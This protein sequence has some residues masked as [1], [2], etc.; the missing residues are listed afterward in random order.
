MAFRR[1][2]D[3]RTTLVRLAVAAGS[4]FALRHTGPVFNDIGAFNLV[5]AG[6]SVALAVSGTLLVSEG[7]FRL[8][9]YFKWLAVNTPEGN[10]GDGGFVRSI[11]ELRADLIPFPMPGPYWGKLGRRA[12]FADFTMA[13]I[14]GPTGS[15][16]DVGHNGPNILSIK[17]SKLV[18]D[19][20]GDTSP[21][22]VPA[23]RARGEE[24]RILNFGAMFTDIL[25]E[26]DQYN[27]LH[28][29]ADSFFRPGGI[30]DVASDLTEFALIIYPASKDGKSGTENSNFWEGGSRSKIRLAICVVILIMGYDA[31]LGD[32]LGLLQDR[33]ALLWH[34][35]WIAGRLEDDNG[36]PLVF[37]MHE[38]PWVD[39]QD[40][41]D[42]DRFATYLRGLAAS[43]AD[44]LNADDSRTADSFLQGSL[45]AMEPHN[46]TT[47]AHKIVQSSTFRFADMKEPGRTVTVFMVADDTRLEANRPIIELIQHCAITEW[48]RAPHK[49]VPVYFL[50]NEAANF[51]I[52]NLREIL[53]FA[54]AY[55][56][57]VALYLQGLSAFRASYSKETLDTVFSEQDALLVLPGQS[58]PD[59]LKLLETYLSQESYVE[60]EYGGDNRGPFG[61]KG[62]GIK[63][64]GRAVMSAESIRRSK[65][66]ILWLKKN[67]PAKVELPSIAGIVPFRTQQA[68]NPFFGKPYR[69]PV[70]LRLWRYMWPG[71][72]VQ[73]ALS[74]FRTL[75]F[76]RRS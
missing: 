19:L 1:Q 5:T 35:L 66:A 23:L 36:N 13:C 20:K 55:G 29:I 22:Y 24:V 68:I 61:L 59:T 65:H 57:R 60:R 50:A 27:P 49:S 15:G 25:G 38:S 46:A 48:K 6:A 75:Q 54:R 72:L 7:F 62:F 74:A 30:C 37:P 3:Q 4:Y 44:L 31:T 47:R 64:T 34:A 69:L 41:A 73:L 32:A 51:V 53:T 63:Q 52:R 10:K 8:S 33:E 70:R 39:Q 14:L 42:I 40:S 67:R 58:E 17:A 76:W 45:L 11:R 43:I 9:Q 56:V 2:W 16:K 28:L 21:T 71:K 18:S 12:I 26:S